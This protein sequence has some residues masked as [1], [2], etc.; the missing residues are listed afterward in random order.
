[1]THA[2][3]IVPRWLHVWAV[4]TL[5][6]P[7]LLLGMGQVVTSHAAGMADPL[8]PTEP[9]YVFS[10]ATPA[11][12]E[13]F[14]QDSSFFVE[15]SHRIAAFTVGG[16]VII[17]TL[18]L[19]GTDPRKA[20]RG[21][22]FAGLVVLIAGFGDLHRELMAQNKLIKEGA[23]SKAEIKVPVRAAATCL[24]GL[25]V[26]LG[27]AA[28][29]LFARGGAVRLLGVLALAA[30]MVQGLFGGVRVLMNELIGP[31]LALIHGMF[32]QVVFGTLTA[33]AVLASRP[34]A[35]GAEAG[36]FGRVAAGVALVVFVQV[37]FGA[38][39]RH[40]PGPLTQRLHMLTAFVAT[41]VVMWF[42]HSAMKV[43][44]VR[45]RVA[46]LVW[47]VS[48]LL[49][50]QV[51]LGVEAWLARFGNGLLSESERMTPAYIA[52]RTLHALIG[53]SLWAVSLTVALSLRRSPGA[54][55]PTLDE[56]AAEWARASAPH[57]SPEPVVSRLRGD[58]R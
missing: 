21:A 27:A 22:A 30:V 55:V 3:R 10:T 23:L 19:V 40:M 5:A 32:A 11:E 2:P 13:R 16:L 8:W 15:H 26:A 29:G 43:P 28:S 37:L 48:L 53:S 17:L 51:A 36:S 42:A 56:P 14:R 31:D 44:A 20:A 46:P 6:A 52:T 45:A 38:L 47:A 25:A 49:V 58:A 50:L 4:A 18:G 34:R 1:M 54:A 33:I 9:W 24:A 41:V 7:L 35:G 57:R 39:V 12:R